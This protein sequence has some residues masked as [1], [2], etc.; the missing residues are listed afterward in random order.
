MTDPAAHQFREGDEVVLANG[1]YQGSLGVFLHA[2]ED[3]KWADI[4]E[5]NGAVRSHPVEWL[6]LAGP[7]GVPGAAGKR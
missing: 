1:A 4:R 5:R 7:A 2:N 6:A 3:P